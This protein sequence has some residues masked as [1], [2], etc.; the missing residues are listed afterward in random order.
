MFLDENKEKVIN[1]LVP[2]AIALGTYLIISLGF[3]IFIEMKFNPE[4]MND[5]V[6][7]FVAFSF[8]I[9]VYSIC[10]YYGKNKLGYFSDQTKFI[11]HLMLMIIFPAFIAFYSGIQAVKAKNLAVPQTSKS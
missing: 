9:F 10:L 11:K 7:V 1:G 8:I 4:K 2:I 5:P 3:D 6:F